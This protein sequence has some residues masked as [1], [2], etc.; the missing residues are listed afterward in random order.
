MHTVIRET[1]SV[2]FPDQPAPGGS[3]PIMGRTDSQLGH[4]QTANVVCVTDLPVFTSDKIEVGVL[5]CWEETRGDDNKVRTRYAG[6]VQ[7]TVEEVYST[8]LCCDSVIDWCHPVTEHVCQDQM[9]YL[10]THQITEV[11]P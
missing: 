7:L 1:R 3:L 4:G 2:L 11:C 5:L 10:V 9:T 6:H 8:S